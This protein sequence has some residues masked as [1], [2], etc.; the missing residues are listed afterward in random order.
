MGAYYHARIHKPEFKE[1][2]ARI[3]S[4]NDILHALGATWIGTIIVILFWALKSYFL[5]CAVIKWWNFALPLFLLSVI[6]WNYFRTGREATRII[7]GITAQFVADEVAEG[8]QI[9][10][11][12]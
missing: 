3:E 7:D 1:A 2:H 6:T 9:N 5:S 12:I 8:G 10:L 11:Y 4:M